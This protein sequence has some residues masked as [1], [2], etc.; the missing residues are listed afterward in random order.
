M[1]ETREV[2]PPVGQEPSTARTVN[3][4]LL[5]LAAGA[6]AKAKRS[7]RKW[8]LVSLVSAPEVAASICRRMLKYQ[9]I[10]FHLDTVCRGRYEP[11]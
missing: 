1:T 2:M 5:Q 8:H 3:E 9:A 11:G 10:A 6:Y 7:R 4:H